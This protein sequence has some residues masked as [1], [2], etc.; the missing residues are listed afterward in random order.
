[1]KCYI[2]VVI[3]VFI[4]VMTT[5]CNPCFFAT[6][7]CYYPFDK[8]SINSDI[9]YYV[10]DNTTDKQRIED[11]R[12]C[13]AVTCPEIHK[14]YKLPDEKGNYLYVIEKTN[15]IEYINCIGANSRCMLN[16]KGY[17]TKW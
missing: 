12:S 10:K 7:Y 1:M 16:N 14:L 5:S 6:S 4:M 3:I 11:F 17:S 13:L 8:Y 9:E 15:N 2:K